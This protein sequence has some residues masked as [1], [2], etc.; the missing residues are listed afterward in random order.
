MKIVVL[1][2]Y[3]EMGRITVIDLFET[4]KGTIVVAGRNEDKAKAFAESF[5]SNNIEWAGADAD[6]PQKLI[7]LLRGSDV[8]INA[9]QY[10]TNLQVMEAALSAETNY[11]DLGG[12]FHM[13]KKQLKLNNSFMK[14]GKLAVAGCGATPGITNIMAAYGS[15]LLDTIDSINVQFADK[16]YT[17]YDMP[18]VVP[19]SMRTI[20]DEFSMEPAVFSDGKLKY[21]KPISGEEEIEFLPPVNRATCF[22]TLHSEVATF[23]SSFKDKGIKNCSFK[24]GF[25]KEFVEK[26]KF[27]IDTG[28]ASTTPVKYKNIDVVPLN[29]TVSL[30]NRF[31]PEKDKIKDLEF[32]RV[33]LRGKRERKKKN[34]VVYCESRS[35]SRWN[36]PAGTWDTGVPPSI[37][38]QMIAENKIEKRGVM[39][40]ELCIDP[41]L[42]FGELAKREIYLSFQENQERIRSLTGAKRH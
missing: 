27:L 23:P 16:D 24:G 21:V 1:G 14:K 17:K 20:F 22:Y 25:P 3:G 9:T 28:F 8:V 6:D 19:Y 33:E 37:I 2:G 40:P 41:E 10:T 11:V 35:N 29:F 34:V 36:I 4:F 38:A 30:L 42:F 18:F 32:L 26:I 13:T 39:P 15:G 12:L 31:I 5:K 7:G